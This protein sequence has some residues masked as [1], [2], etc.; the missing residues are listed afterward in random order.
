MCE[1]SFA[2]PVAATNSLV[3]DVDLAVGYCDNLW[4][5]RRERE[6][7]GLPCDGGEGDG[8]DEDV[9]EG[10]LGFGDDCEGFD[11]MYGE[12]EDRPSFIGEEGDG[13]VRNGES[14][15]RTDG[16]KKAPLEVLHEAL[17]TPNRFLLLDPLVAVAFSLQGGDDT[18]PYLPLIEVA[19]E[20]EGGDPAKAVKI[21]AM[22]RDYIDQAAAL[23][24]LPDNTP[25]SLL[26]GDVL[27]PAFRAAESRVRQLTVAANLVRQRYAELQR[28]ATEA[29]IRSQSNLN[30]VEAIKRLGVGALLKSR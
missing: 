23:R 28:K 8:P 2:H 30:K 27:I 12:G 20:A 16:G 6:E 7:S 13:E 21:M 26:A 18:C 11:G 17:L 5:V 25:M 9:E 29:S 19:L 3:A 1:G 14:E 22:R 15:E 4:E 10:V 24:A